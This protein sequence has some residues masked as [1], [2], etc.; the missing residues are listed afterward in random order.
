L[1]AEFARQYA[2]SQHFF[3]ASLASPG[4]QYRPSY[5][6]KAGVM[7]TIPNAKC[8]PHLALLGPD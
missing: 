4:M 2:S 7:P 6:V 3:C 1:A 8:L 5:M